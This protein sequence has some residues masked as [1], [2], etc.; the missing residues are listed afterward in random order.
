MS[1]TA[2]PIDD[3]LPDLLAALRKAGQAVLQAPPGAGK[4]TRVPLAILQAGLVPGRIVMLE[5]RRLA[6]RAA[7][8]RMA[9]TLGEPL[10]QTVG[11]RIRGE[12]V[13]GA[14]HQPAGGERGAVLG[15]P[16]GDVA[17]VG[18]GVHLLGVGALHQQAV[19]VVLDALAAGHVFFVADAVAFAQVDDPPALAGRQRQA[20]VEGGRVGSGARRQ[21]QAGGESR[22]ADRE[23]TE[24]SAHEASLPRSKRFVGGLNSHE[25]L[26]DRRDARR[27]DIILCF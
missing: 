21:Q 27:F 9:E 1:Q 13:P 6:A 24:K 25:S 4:T 23:T 20:P 22:E 10:G 12:A 11:Y 8:E 16:G 2:L 19:A 3:A 5:P 7:A 14:T 26:H 17:Q 18:L 15:Q